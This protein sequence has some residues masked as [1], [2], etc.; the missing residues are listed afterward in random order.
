[1]PDIADVRKEERTHF[2]PT[3]VTCHVHVNCELLLSVLSP[4]YCREVNTLFIEDYQEDSR[5]FVL[6]VQVEDNLTHAVEGHGHGGVLEAV[7]LGRAA[8]QRAG[9]TH[10]TV[11]EIIAA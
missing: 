4:A 6:R 7:H 10:Q 2:H 1:M 8:G 3:R 5:I 11:V 9:P